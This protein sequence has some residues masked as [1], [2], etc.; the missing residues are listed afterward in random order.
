MPGEP[1]EELR[2]RQALPYPPRMTSLA[3][4]TPANIAGLVTVRILNRTVIRPS[5]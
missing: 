5:F 4:M 1:V 2:W 3:S